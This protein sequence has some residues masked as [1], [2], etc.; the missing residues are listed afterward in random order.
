MYIDLYNFLCLKEKLGP[1]ETRTRI[2]RFRVYCAYH[3][4]IRPLKCFHSNYIINYTYS[5]LIFP[6]AGALSFPNDS[7]AYISTSYSPLLILLG[8]FTVREL[9][10]S[11]FIKKKSEK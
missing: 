11:S 5:I 4:T 7:I 9:P 2:N 6:F 8:I 10:L 3:Y 1:T